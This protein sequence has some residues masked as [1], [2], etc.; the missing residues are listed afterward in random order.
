MAAGAQRPAETQSFFS[1]IGLIL[2]SIIDAPKSK[3]V[4]TDSCSNL[5][6]ML[7]HYL[8]LVIQANCFVELPNLSDFTKVLNVLR[9]QQIFQL[10]YME[11]IIIQSLSSSI[12]DRAGIK[13]Y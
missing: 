6:Q 3:L 7:D 5:H 10:S 8:S 2:I 12:N 4:V 13:G 9:C 11:G 1:C